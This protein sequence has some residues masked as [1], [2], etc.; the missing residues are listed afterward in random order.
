MI[1]WKQIAIEFIDTCSFK[2]DIE[3]AFLT[4]GYLY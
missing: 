3:A 2:G 4:R 1:N